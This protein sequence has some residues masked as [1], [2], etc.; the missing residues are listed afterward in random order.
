MGRP[1]I[2]SEVVKASSKFW[3][4]WGGAGLITVTRSPSRKM[5]LERR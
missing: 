5:G 2:I 1:L 4:L 3:V